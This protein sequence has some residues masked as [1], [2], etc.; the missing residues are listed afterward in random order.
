MFNWILS[1]ILK[2]SEKNLHASHAGCDFIEFGVYVRSRESLSLLR[3]HISWEN[4]TEKNNSL[5]AADGEM[6]SLI[7]RDCLMF[8]FMMEIFV[9]LMCVC[10][11]FFCSL[12]SCLWRK[13]SN[14]TYRVTV[15]RNIARE[16]YVSQN[17]DD[18]YIVHCEM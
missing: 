2:D 10:V 8:S 17:T 6:A 3:G 16:G 12:I 14:K 7:H 11:C 9:L 15:Q 5:L 1:S 18:I 4:N 13:Y